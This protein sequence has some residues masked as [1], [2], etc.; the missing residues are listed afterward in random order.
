[1]PLDGLGRYVEKFSELHVVQNFWSCIPHSIDEPIVEKPIEFLAISLIKSDPN[2][3]P[4]KTLISPLF[5]CRCKST[6]TSNLLFRIVRRKGQI[7]R[8]NVAYR[9]Q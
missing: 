1:M 9:R 4:E 5:K 2:G 8:T 6:T 7:P 3:A